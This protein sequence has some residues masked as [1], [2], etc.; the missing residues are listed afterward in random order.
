METKKF[1]IQV[2]KRLGQAY[3]VCED[4]IIIISPSSSPMLETLPGSEIITENSTL[5]FLDLK[6]EI[7]FVEYIANLIEK[8][9]ENV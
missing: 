5:L 4:D 6:Q 9:S 7:D 8:A 3:S 2:L 1:I